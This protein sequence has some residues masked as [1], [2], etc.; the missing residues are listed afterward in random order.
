LSVHISLYAIDI[1]NTHNVDLTLYKTS[2]DITHVYA[3]IFTCHVVLR[4][5]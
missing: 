4:H 1:N 5:C 2:F 3:I